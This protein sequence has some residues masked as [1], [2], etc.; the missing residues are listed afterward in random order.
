MRISGH[1]TRN[2]FDRYNIID[3]EDVAAAAKRLEGIRRVI[4]PARLT[5]ENHYRT[6]T[7]HIRRKRG[8][9][10]VAKHLRRWRNWQTH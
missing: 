7:V 10:K 4:P 5:I 9:L 1:R 6:T 2:I 8:K 3:E